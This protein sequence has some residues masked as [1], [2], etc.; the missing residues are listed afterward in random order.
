[1]HPIRSLDG[2]GLPYPGQSHRPKAETPLLGG[3][4]VNIPHG[5]QHEGTG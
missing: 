2:K 5:A 3:H 1:V 4:G